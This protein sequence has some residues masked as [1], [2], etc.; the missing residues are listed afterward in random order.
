M[1]AN[2]TSHAAVALGDGRVLILGGQNMVG[3]SLSSSEIYSPPTRSF[4][5]GPALATPR[6]MH[7]ATMLRDGTVLVI[8]GFRTSGGTQTWLGTAEIVELRAGQ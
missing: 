4:T 5:A 8:G 6:T 3:D 1:L 2:R 7:T